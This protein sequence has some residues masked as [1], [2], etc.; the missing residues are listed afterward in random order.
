MDPNTHMYYCLFCFG[1]CLDEQ[2]KY[3][4]VID[5]KIY[6]LVFSTSN[7]CLF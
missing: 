7:L 5:S 3:Y 6:G 4:I 1:N 2:K